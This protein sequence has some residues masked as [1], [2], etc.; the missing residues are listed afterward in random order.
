MDGRTEDSLKRKA[1]KTDIS[2]VLEES[3]YFLLSSWW[4]MFI[5]PNFASQSVFSI[6]TSLR[7]RWVNLL[8]CDNHGNLKLDSCSFKC[9]KLVIQRQNKTLALLQTVKVSLCC[10]T[11]NK[12][13]QSPLQVLFHIKLLLICSP[14][15]RYCFNWLILNYLFNLYFFLF[16]NSRLQRPW[17]NLSISGTLWQTAVTSGPWL[18]GGSECDHIPCRDIL[19]D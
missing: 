6:P 14:L 15:K 2:V 17:R 9:F 8:L 16:Y 3:R 11:T 13:W 12:L 5:V 19:C 7:G 1:N 18:E 10:W 4:Q